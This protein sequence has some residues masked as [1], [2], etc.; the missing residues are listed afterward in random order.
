M[1]NKKILRF[2]I[3]EDYIS[4]DLLE[5]MKESIISKTTLC[6]PKQTIKSLNST[7]ISGDKFISTPNKDSNPDSSFLSNFDYSSS[8]QI[9][10]CK[11]NEIRKN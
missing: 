10:D 6:S 3:E 5:S 7:L 1:S 8:P 2:L 4:Y 9:S 11:F